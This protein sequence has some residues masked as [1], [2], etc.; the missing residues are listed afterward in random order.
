MQVVG[1]G[2]VVLRDFGIGG[3]E[4]VRRTRWGRFLWFV[5]RRG[6]DRRDLL[7]DFERRC[8]G[9]LVLILRLGL[10]VSCGGA[11]GPGAGV[12]DADGVDVAAVVVVAVVGEDGVVIDGVS[13]VGLR[14]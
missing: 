14:D 2:R 8:A 9:A 5:R 3:G 1:N 11:D 4:L 13:G 7:R 12:D 6:D 10:V